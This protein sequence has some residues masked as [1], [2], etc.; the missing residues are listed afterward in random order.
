MAQRDEDLLRV[1]EIIAQGGRVDITGRSGSGRTHL[2]DQLCADLL[3]EEWQVLHVRGSE[4]LRAIPLAALMTAGLSVP[5][6]GST[7]AAAAANCLAELLKRSARARQFVAVDDW[8]SVDDAS[9][10]VIEQASR[11]GGVAFAL[12]RRIGWRAGAARE[13]ER[14][15][16]ADPTMTVTLQPLGYEDLQDLLRERLGGDIEGSTMS[17]IY[18]DSDG[19][20]SLSFALVDAALRES[21]LALRD[22]LWVA[23]A[24]LWSPMLTAS[25]GRILAPLGEQERAAL[26]LLALTGVVDLAAAAEIAGEPA[27]EALEERHLLRLHPSGRGYLVMVTPPLLAEHIRRTQ[28]VARR[29]RLRAQ[30]ERRLASRD[31]SWAPPDDGLSQLESPAGFVHIIREQLSTDLLIAHAAWRH[32]PTAET[33]ATYVEALLA[34]TA[35]P[36]QVDRILDRGLEAPGGE[37][38][39]ARLLVLAAQHRAHA[40]GELAEALA[41][42]RDGEARIAGQAALLRAWGVAIELALRAVPADHEQ[43]LALADEPSPDEPPSA[44]ATRHWIA[45]LVATTQGRLAD[46]ELHLDRQR[47]ALDGQL[48]DRGLVLHGLNLMGFGRIDE[49][50]DLA[51]R[52]IE[53]ARSSFQATALRRYS[54]LAVWC[55][56]LRGNYGGF[57]TI[58]EDVFGLGD[59]P[60]SSQLTQLAMLS[61]SALVAERQ[62]KS[63]LA[64]R[65]RTQLARIDLPDGP[66]PGM[67]RGLSEL[68]ALAGA[69]QHA[70]AAQRGRVIA[71]ALWDR[72]FRYSAA[73]GYSLIIELDPD[74]ARHREVDDR[75]GA[76]EGEYFA[77]QRTY[78]AALVADDADGLAA[79]ADR[80][81]RSGRPDQAISAL[82]RAADLLTAANRAHDADQARRHAAAIA[83]DNPPGTYDLHRYGGQPVRLT[84][85]EREIVGLIARGMSNNDVAA[86]L[87]VS[88]RT[89]ESHINH[90]IA[91]TAVAS[92]ADFKALA[93]RLSD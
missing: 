14:G 57:E 60:E 50:L 1:H 90:I 27:I 2:L 37:E 21:R 83:T 13:A 25:V 91:K 44:A 7:L 89:I 26:D 28:P 87:S 23:T 65:Y 84:P 24:D 61:M 10:G 67:I 55:F 29:V 58:A 92:R 15:T 70:E 3:N 48:D 6:T 20:I 17:R 81:A 45:A 82:T 46:S 66:L 69:R 19:N 56:M 35:P 78:L 64:R 62:G 85:R 11:A 41:D 40:D 31:S 22:G 16:L 93:V 72:G 34:D 54:Y 79:S 63:R 74:P 75:I 4:S 49:A 36:G 39:R 73:F 76:V 38:A 32:Q 43:R 71:D 8:E 18:A 59:P 86:Q 30:I 52:G 77:A 42:L 80:L 88:T 12:T 68:Q 9:R 33:A 53:E 47:D 5:T 51:L